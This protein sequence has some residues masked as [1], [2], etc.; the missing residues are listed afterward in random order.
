MNHLIYLAH[1]GQDYYNEA[2]FSLLS[3]FSYNAEI[4]NQVVIYTDNPSFFTLHLAQNILFVP[5]TPELINEW[6]GPDGFNHRMKIKVLQ[7]AAQKFKG[8]LL[9]VD[10]DT[11]FRQDVSGLFD[12]IAKGNI[13]FDRCEGRLMD[14]PGGIARKMRKFLNRQNTFSIPSLKEKVVLTPQMT[15]Y[16][17]GIIGLKATDSHKL[18]QAEELTDLLYGSYKLFVME[19]VA[20]NYILQAGNTVTDAEPYIHHYW[21]FKEFR[22]VLAEFIAKYSPE[23][24]E[25]MKAA[26]HRIDPEELAINKR[27][28]KKMS[29]WQKQWQKLTRGYKWKIPEYRL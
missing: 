19:Q 18:K 10:T 4:E 16:N 8:N 3:Y 2:L 23:G 25:S 26:I 28:Y 27:V 15:V 20:F 13:V 7:D 12:A 24:F 22:P 21:Y 6:K 11:V 14:N 9:Y 17:A 29:F 5:L 1:G